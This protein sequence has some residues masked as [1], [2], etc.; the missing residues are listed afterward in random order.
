MY[1]FERIALKFYVAES[2]QIFPFTLHTNL[3]FEIFISVIYSVKNAIY[4]T[5][6]A[7]CLQFLQVT[8][9]TKVDFVDKILSE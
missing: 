8:L 6:Y 7:D 4:Y 5:S 9:D 3:N 1:M 2:A